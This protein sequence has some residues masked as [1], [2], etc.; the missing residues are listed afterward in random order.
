MHQLENRLAQRR[1]EALLP[2]TS[3]RS[4]VLDY[5]HE[6]TERTVRFATGVKAKS[7]VRLGALHK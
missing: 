3:A 5:G 6:V 2:L 7:L 1:S 4:Y